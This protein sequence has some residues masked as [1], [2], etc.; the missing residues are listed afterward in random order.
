M[1]WSEDAIHNTAVAFLS[2]AQNRRGVVACLS[3]CVSTILFM[4]NTHIQ[5]AVED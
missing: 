5:H 2:F 1:T 3:F 4:H